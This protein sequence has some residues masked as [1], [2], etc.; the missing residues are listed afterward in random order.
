ML[1]THYRVVARR[2]RF[3]P[4]VLES[5]CWRGADGGQFGRNGSG[6]PVSSITWELE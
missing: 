1:M 6:F 2:S 4:S 3:G 5:E